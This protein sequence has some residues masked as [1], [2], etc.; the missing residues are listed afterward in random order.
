MPLSINSGVHLE[1]IQGEQ[2]QLWS[3]PVNTIHPFSN[4]LSSPLSFDL[5]VTVCSP[6]TLV[7]LP[8]ISHSYVRPSQ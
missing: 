4:L 3:L 6:S 8:L 1:G 7:A 5:S 2:H